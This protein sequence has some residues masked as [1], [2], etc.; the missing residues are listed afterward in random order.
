MKWVLIFLSLSGAAFAREKLYTDSNTA[1]IGPQALVQ[2]H[3]LRLAGVTELL[4]PTWFPA[5]LHNLRVKTAESEIGRYGPELQMEWPASNPRR[6]LLVQG[7]SGGFGGPGPDRTVPVF[8]ATLGTIP[9][10]VNFQSPMSWRY[11]TD[12]L[13][14][15]GS[16]Y[17]VL[18]GCNGR[19]DGV[20]SPDEMKQMIASLRY[21][22]IP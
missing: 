1:H 14:I 8:N 3:K 16:K 19:T 18:Y 5:D 6:S 12:W 7:G 20:L 15:A 21:Y 22:R 2:L 9:M 11:S 10:W 17:Y 13:P 4:V